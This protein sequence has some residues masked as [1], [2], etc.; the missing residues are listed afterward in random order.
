MRKLLFYH[1]CLL[2]TFCLC[3]LLN[4]VRTTALTMHKCLIS[5]RMYVRTRKSGY[6]FL[7]I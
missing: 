3:C 2:E 5:V 1:A 4:G 6:D 7:T